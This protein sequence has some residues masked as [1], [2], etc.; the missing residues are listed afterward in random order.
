MT[1]VT[2][3]LRLFLMRWAKILQ[4][5]PVS[6][7]TEELHYKQRTIEEKTNENPPNN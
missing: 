4:N 1:N 6:K 7:T 3:P 2:S 5:P